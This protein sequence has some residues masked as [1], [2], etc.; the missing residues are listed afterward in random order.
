LLAGVLDAS[1]SSR[2]KDRLHKGAATF[3]TLIGVWWV[4]LASSWTRDPA[5]G[6]S[7]PAYGGAF[8]LLISY[9]IRGAIYRDW[10]PRTPPICA[11]IVCAS[12]P[13][14]WMAEDVMNASPGFLA[15]SA[16]FLLFA[17][18][19]LVAFSKPKHS[20]VPGEPEPSP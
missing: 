3:R 7:L 11:L 2:W 8:I 13:G 10:K 12:K 18:G 4:L 5:Y 9:G 1:F 15:I 16:S 17:L 6:V 20:S 19:S 14:V